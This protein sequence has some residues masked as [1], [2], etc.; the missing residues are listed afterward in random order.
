MMLVAKAKVAAVVVGIGILLAGCSTG[1]WVSTADHVTIGK[2]QSL[3]CYRLV[4]IDAQGRAEFRN[5]DTGDNDVLAHVIAAPGQTFGCQ[6]A[7][8]RIH[9]DFRIE[10]TDPAKQQ[11]TVLVTA[12]RRK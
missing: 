7:N 2:G 10:G 11:A 6:G 3:E 8:P 4:S 1:N 9:F 12:S 5:T